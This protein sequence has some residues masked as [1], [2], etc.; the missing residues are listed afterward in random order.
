MRNKL[1][2]DVLDDIEEIG[3]VPEEEELPFT[4]EPVSGDWP[5]MVQIIVDSFRKRVPKERRLETVSEIASFITDTFSADAEIS[6][7][8]IYGDFGIADEAIYYR[9]TFEF[10]LTGHPGMTVRRAVRLLT[11]LDVVGSLI[12]RLCGKKPT[13]SQSNYFE[14]TE[15]FDRPV[16]IADT[17]NLGQN[18]QRKMHRAIES[19]SFPLSFDSIKNSSNLERFR[20]VI[21]TICGLPAGDTMFGL[22]TADSM[23]E[24]LKEKFVEMAQAVKNEYDRIRKR[25]GN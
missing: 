10:G 4:T 6:A 15:F 13:T 9:P 20:K 25:N 21:F 19:A 2:E 1:Y 5:V 3:P 16:T 11:R 17:N 24:A 12:A 23:D 14:Y 8:S 7:V 22:S 18:M